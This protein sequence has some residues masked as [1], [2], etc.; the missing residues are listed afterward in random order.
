MMSNLI[1]EIRAMSPEEQAELA[2]ILDKAKETTKHKQIPQRIEEPMLNPRDHDA[3]GNALS[4]EE[5]WNREHP[6]ILRNYGHCETR[7]DYGKPESKRY[8]KDEEVDAYNAEQ[9]RLWLEAKRK[10][11]PN[12]T[13]PED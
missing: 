1:E 2:A 4:P 13:L 8:W 3:Y 5:I 10:V 12:A 6:L 9:K 11:F 7:H